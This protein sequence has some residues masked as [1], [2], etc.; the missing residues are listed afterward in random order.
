MEAVDLVGRLALQDR[1]TAL[2]FVKRTPI[3]LVNSLVA[4]AWN[5]VE[6]PPPWASA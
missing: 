1:A 5:A 4:S 3:S 6:V 2:I